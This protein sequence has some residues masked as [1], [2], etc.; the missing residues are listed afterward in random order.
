MSH[1]R[2]T[3]PPALFLLVAI[4]MSAAL[5]SAGKAAG[6]DPCAVPVTNK[7]ACENTKPG[8]PEE[9]WAVEGIGQKSIQ[10][11]ATQM[12][13]DLGQTVNFKIDT[14]ST[15]Y[16]IDI[17]RLGY[18][19]GDGARM[20]KS[21][22]LPSASLPQAQPPCERK[23]E[24]GLV[25]CGKWNVSASWTVPTTAVSGLYIAHLVR[26]DNGKGEEGSQIF[27]VVRDDASHSA[28][29]L[30]TSDTTW[31]AYNAYGGNSLYTCTVACP[32]GEPG[33]YKAAYAVSY[34]RPFD[35]TLETDNG[36]SDPFYAEYQLI[37]FLE[38]NGYDLS[39]ISQ[40]D[41]DAQPELLKNHKIFISSGHDE[42]WS[43]EERSAVEEA[44]D[45]GV[46]LAFFSGNELFWKTRWEASKDG[47]NTAYRTLVDYKDT[48][49]PA[50]VDPAYPKVTTSSWRDP[51]FSPPADAGKPENSLTGQYF[52]VNSGTS[53]I[54]V[55]GT[56]A[57]NRFWRNTEVSTLKSNQTLTLDPGMGTL[58]YEWDIDADNGFRPAGRIPLSSTTVSGLQTF[59]DYGTE[60]EE[61]TQT[62]SLSLYKAPSGALVFG[63][64]TVQWAWGLDATNVW[65]NS[66]PDTDET[67][68]TMQQATVNL[69]ADMGAQPATLQPELVATTASTDTSA[70]TATVSSPAAEAELS[71]GHTVTISGTAA[72]TGGGVV[73][74]VEVS[75][76]GGQTWHPAVGTTSWTYSWIV[77]GSPSTV[78]KA[79]AT[80]DSANIGAP[81]SGTKVNVDCPCTIFANT[82]PTNPDGGDGESV[83]V[84]VKFRSDTPGTVT[85]IRFYKAAANTGTHIGALWSSTGT[86]LAVVT[87][88]GESATGWQEAEFSKP[89]E[90]QANTTYVASY[91]APEGH[92]S[93]TPFALNHPPP[94]GTD[95]LDAPPLHVLPDDQFGN[96]VFRYTEDSAFPTDTY[97]SANYWVDV[98]FRPSAPATAPGAP[99]GVSATAGTGQATINWSAPANDGGSPITGYTVTPYIGSTAQTPVAVSAPASSKTI[100]G[101]TAGTAYNFTVTAVN[102]VGS[103][104]ESAHSNSVTPTA[105]TVPTAPGTPSAN[106]G[107][108]Q[109]T[110]NWSAPS[111]DGGAAITSYRITPYV[112]ATALTPVN[113]GSTTTGAT[114]T[115]LTNGT[116]Y[117]F[118]VAATNSIGTGPESAHSPSVTPSAI[119][120]PGAPTALTA[121]A[122]S[123]GAQLSWTAPASNGGGAITGYRITP[124]I[125]ATAQTPVNTGNTTT[126]AS[127]SGLT[128]GTTYTFTVAAINGAG[129]GAE[130]AASAAITPN[131]MIFDLATPSLVDSDDGS[132]VELGVKFRADVNGTVN[133]IRFYKAAANTGT[134][135]GSLWTATGTLLAQ[136]TFSGETASGWQQVKFSSPVAITAN[137]T[138]V[139]GYF[140]P[141]G[142]YSA[143]GPTL[144]TGVDNP[145]LHAIS[146]A[147]SANGIYA[148]GSSPTFPTSTFQSSNYWVDVLFTVST[149][150]T[151]PGAPTGVSAT[152]GTG[153][154][155][156]NWSAP[157]NDGGSPITGYTVTPYIGSTAQTPVAVSAP[158]SSKTISGLTAGTA[159]NF[160]VTA[161]NAVGSGAESAH[162]NSV[163]P[164]ANTVPT[165]PGTPSANGGPAQATLNWSAPSSDGGAAITSYR[166]TPYVGA[167]A[168]TPVNTGSTTTG[169]TVTGL[170]NGTAY[171]FTVAAT[172]SIGTG[173]ESAHS[174][175][176]TPSA[177]N[178]PGAPT[179]LTA[180]AKS[181]GAQ[182]SWT[183]P[184]SNG[185]GAITG[186]RITPYIG[187]TAQTPVNTG[188]TTTTA[189]VS[190]LTNGTT[191]TFTVA[192][193]NGAGPGAESAA[194][195]AITPNAMIFDL[196]TPSLV[197]SDDGSAVELGVKFR[198]DVNGTVNG[199]RFYKAAANTGTHIGSL[200]TATG[201]LLAQA[202]FSGETAS[203]WQQVKFSS[204]VAITANTTYV[205]G[206]FAPNGHYSANGPTL[207]TG[208][209]NPP[210]HAIS[211][212][213]SANGIYAYGSSPTFPT[214]TFQSSNYW[215]DVLF[216]VSTPA[217][218]PG[219]PTG[220]SA[221]AG[222]G[223]ATINWSAP[224]NDGG[225]PITGYTV[226]PY[227]GS[228]AQTPV[229]VS[230]PAS[231]KTISGLTAGTAYNFTVTAVN[232]VG[233]GAESAHSNS[234]TPTANTVPTAPGT[235]SANGGPA[236]ATLNWSAPSSD[237]G[238]AIT[239][240]RITPYVGATALTPVNT[241]STTTGAT[242]TGLTNGTA[243]TFTVAA[244]NSIGTGPESAHSPSVTPSAINP[245]GAPTALTAAAKSAGAQ[246]SWTAPASNGGGAITG[247]RITPYIGAT[248]QTPV[249][250]G[251]TTTTAS[252]SGLTNGTTYTFT[253]AAING[254]GPGAESAASAAITPNAM[255]FDLATPS[256]VDSDDGSAVE[257]GVKFRADVNGT[258]NGIRF[259]KAAA[260]TGTHIGSLW[261]ATGT[262]LAQATFSGE[263]ASGW[264]QVKFSSPVAITANTTY[265]AGYFAP[266]G[267]YSANGPTLATGVDNPP[268][269]AISNATSA[270]GIYA[271]G[272]SPTFPTST[273]QSS[274]YWVD[275]LF[276]AQG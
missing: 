116:A 120:P 241:G 149:P 119:N 31:Q 240:Y 25:E 217:T 215:V 9:D 65:D 140:A 265:V 79:R 7:V 219:A 51:R 88:S 227:I 182:L 124:Y 132:A 162:S 188:N 87:F 5:P 178:P 2:R 226:T 268:L 185:G 173:P 267:H 62:H 18:Y 44:R 24:T 230:A 177:I 203:G 100:S 223:Q 77:H 40:H 201:T 153:Q 56:F 93:A 60:L 117:T 3:L 170:T 174:P 175:S 187:A 53:E 94:T 20:I 70:P 243:Y 59:K 220:V 270:N 99:T 209:D 229:A 112:G 225:S 152:A 257:L 110:L 180:A 234:V 208:V 141:N 192:A 131:A 252:V 266:N 207:A 254:A 210:L 273:F 11:Y 75:T 49:F 73:A 64:G 55:P 242:V 255:I 206:Y 39:Y 250:T 37:R 121:A 205:A 15:K 271:Y 200:W 133:G 48:H 89:A 109:A 165:A 84:G 214:S 246:L 54:T 97:Q 78:I 263:T 27:F 34:N 245:P 199:I 169:A 251:N 197:D 164:T 145:P 76:D 21:D 166:I 228:T 196:A 211:N 29:V 81:T 235:P 239:S 52:V 218:A 128:N 30:K 45:Q 108:A 193:I 86:Q 33:G 248:A 213:T 26:D 212:A 74:A 104:A 6:P 91:F 35:G 101:L 247:Y 69:F 23:E 224:A 134:H 233:S 161:V 38:R 114:V 191:Y 259:Y 47:S 96:G 144:A 57:K 190:G 8:D 181:A 126:T 92:Y 50:P 168:L 232:A 32:E 163:T 107:P 249:N 105:N 231:S 16:H 264:Q 146:N 63:A 256:L 151:A 171:T 159:Y 150:A 172:N 82:A 160:T 95:N 17:L 127:V 236:Q 41:V 71:D 118:T 66:G 138:Y 130:S 142:H 106:G 1:M 43:A 22:L 113:T 186:Y 61:S 244:T 122:K 13:V 275:V 90:I 85:G 58:G 237:G 67:D 202:T 115:G 19:D 198:A 10:G 204:P 42:Y 36:F 46:N 272:S 158:A 28:A 155:T 136:A 154:A 183:A 238:A 125:G 102:A 103:G 147:T 156:I 83:E 222:T 195:A 184:A 72:D 68:P 216:T 148:Y 143:N 123:A 176:V 14:P 4:A 276:T 129:P 135:I 157:A 258:V 139:A 80:D 260:N 269:H 274:N 137:T 111:S 167:T 179:A 261:T 98:R 189:S 221:T 262:L 12:S 253:V 194:S